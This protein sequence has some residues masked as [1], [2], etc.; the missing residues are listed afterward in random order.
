MNRTFAVVIVAALA[1]CLSSIERTIAAPPAAPPAA[2]APPCTKCSEK[3][4]CKDK[5]KA[6][7]TLAA[8]IKAIK[9]VC[10]QT[11]STDEGESCESE[12][13]DGTCCKGKSEGI[14]KKEKAISVAQW[15]SP[16]RCDDA[17]KEQ[18]SIDID[19]TLPI[20]PLAP[21][22]ISFTATKS[23]CPG[24]T[25]EHSACAGACPTTA[26][27]TCSEAK[28]VH[29]SAIP[30]P[31]I[32]PFAKSP[33]DVASPIVLPTPHAWTIPLPQQAPHPI[34]QTS[35]DVIFS[36]PVPTRT[37]C[38]LASAASAAPADKVSQ[39][40]F[41]IQVIEDRTGCLAE[42]ESFQNGDCILF[43]DSKTLLPALRILEKHNLV[44]SVASPKLV[45]ITGRRAQMEVGAEVATG[46]EP[47]WQGVKVEVE[48]EKYESG[49][50]ID[51]AVHTSD[52][53]HTCDVRT[54]VL[55][56]EGQ[57]IVLKSQTAS[58]AG[59]EEDCCCKP[60][61]YVVLTPE[62]MK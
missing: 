2:P 6:D 10:A 15:P 42:Y 50:K 49:L 43:A 48:A 45:C 12:C 31:V 56:D 23:A 7:T 55:L 33:V 58:A 9:T 3:S 4:C 39:V 16:D 30:A 20:P 22:A 26:K 52:K 44:G 54:A 59:D 11:I 40:L 28:T 51:F 5:A 35:A 41:N 27:A 32:S 29:Y 18:A 62:L 34:L 8:A 36:N 53:E 14:A 46:E 21:P 17:A 57:T 25:C 24:S 1:L 13:A 37:D 60:T 61:T 19:V 38:A 47:H